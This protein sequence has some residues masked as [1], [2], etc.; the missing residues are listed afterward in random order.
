[1]TLLRG[2]PSNVFDHL[3]DRYDA[4]FDSAEGKPLFEMETRCL[5]DLMGDAN[6]RWVEIGVGTGRFSRHWRSFSERNFQVALLLEK[7]I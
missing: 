2:Q 6:G 5:Q 1:M 3:T 4:W 7:E